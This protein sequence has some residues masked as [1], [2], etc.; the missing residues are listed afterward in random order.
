MKQMLCERVKVHCRVR[1][2]NI[3]LQHEEP[4]SDEDENVFITGDCNNEFERVCLKASSDKIEFI[5]NEKDCGGMKEFTFDSA[6]QPEAKQEMV[7]NATAQDIVQ[8]GSCFNEQF[9]GRLLMIIVF[10]E[11]LGWL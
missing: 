9:D 6:F 8:V 4:A 2:G 10:L 5:H 1:P 7:Y 11:R 3:L